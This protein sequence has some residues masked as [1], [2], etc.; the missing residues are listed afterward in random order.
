MVDKSFTN[1]DVYLGD[2]IYKGDNRFTFRKSIV[3][4]ASACLWIQ[5]IAKYNNKVY[6]GYGMRCVFTL[7]PKFTDLKELFNASVDVAKVSVLKK[8]LG[9]DTPINDIYNKVV[10]NKIKIDVIDY[11]FRYLTID[12]NINTITRKGKKYNIVRD[13]NTGRIKSF[14]RFERIDTKEIKGIAKSFKN[15]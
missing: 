4:G 9:T 11:G 10:K 7:D 14:R 3:Y 6:T 12:R 1:G 2:S 15:D 5:V 8:V 13:K